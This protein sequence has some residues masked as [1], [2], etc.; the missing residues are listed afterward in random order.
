[1]SNFKLG[2]LLFISTTVGTVLFWMGLFFW[3]DEPIGNIIE[4]ARATFILKPES[5]LNYKDAV[6][7]GRLVEK[8]I[9]LEGNDL[10]SQISG[11]Y[12]TI[13]TILVTLLTILGISIPLYIKTNAENIAS[14]QTKQE[15]VRY[16]SENRG[17][18][19]ALREALERESPMIRNS[20]ATMLDTTSEDISS[21]QQQL[22]ELTPIIENLQGLDVSEINRMKE[23]IQAIESY[24]QQLDPEVVNAE[25][26]QIEGI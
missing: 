21:I 16:C 1:M 23:N 4:E 10:L 3:F 7:L 8:G 11:F 5:A 17:F 15:V 6:T 20:V 13:I 19:D 9:V 14:R 25:Q 26:G 18:Y 12:T 22:E 24:V 2:L